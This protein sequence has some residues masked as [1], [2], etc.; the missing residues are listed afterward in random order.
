MV[1]VDS[2]VWIDLLKNRETVET[3]AFER[4][5]AEEEIIIGDLI[6]FEVLRG[7]RPLDRVEKIKS[8]LLTFPVHTIGG[9]DTVLEAVHN[10]LLMNARGVQVRAIDCLI[11]TFCIISGSRLLTSDHDFYPFAD[12]LG[13]RLAGQ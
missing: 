9:V 4:L 1:M 11:A 13:L 6:L 8:H 12:V 10:S 3:Q 2:S 7:V 5:A